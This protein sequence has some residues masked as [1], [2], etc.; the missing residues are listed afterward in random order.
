MVQPS[1][2][3]NPFPGLRPFE[4]DEEHLFFGREGQADELL[5]RLNRTRFLA[6]VGTS[7]SGKSSLVRAGLLPSLYSGLMPNA[8]SGWRVA[9]L[10]PGHAPMGNLAEALNE[11]K[12]FGVDAAADDAIIR[13]ALT[14]STLRRGAL[15]LVEVARQA[16]M[17]NHES[18][19]VVVDQFEE[20]FR[21]K[22]QAQG[23]DHRLAV[24]D[25]AAAFVKLLLGAVNQQEVPI[26]VVLTMRS[27][28]LG[29]CAQFRDLPETL[30]NSQYLVPRLTREQLKLAIEGP[31]AVGGATITPRL[32]NRLLNDTG[33]NPDQLPILQH[34]LMRTW[35]YWEDQHQPQTPI[36]IEHY[37]AIGGMAKAL[38]RHADQIYEGLPDER[39]RRI[40]EILFRCLTTRGVDNRDI[41]RPTQLA[42]IC[43][44][45][46]AS[47]AEVI[48]VIDQFRA[49]RRSFLMP[50]LQ[51]SLHDQ[52]II[53]ISHESLMRNWGRLKTWVTLEEQSAQIYK[54]LA[55]TAELHARGEAGYLRDPELTI[56]LTWLNEQQPNKTWAERYAPNFD[57]AV[58]F[59]AASAEARDIEVA[60]AETA[61][62]QKI[63]QL[64]TFLGVLLGLSVLSIAF[65][66]FALNQ[67][68]RAED[69]AKVAETQ[70]RIA[71][72]Q[73]KIADRQTKIAN[74]KAVEA[75][76]ER[77]RA[78][79]KT[80]EAEQEKE[81]ALRE[82]DAA[83]KAKNEEA[84][85][86][87]I[88]L[89]ALDRAEKGEKEA[90]DQSLRAAHQA[91][92]AQTERDNATAATR[93]ALQEKSYAELLSIE[94][95]I[96]SGLYF[97]A[98]LN[99]LKIIKEIQT[100]SD[101]SKPNQMLALSS[102]REA[103]YH[104]NSSL[105]NFRERNRLNN[106]SSS[107][108]FSPDGQSVVSGHSQAIDFWDFAQGKSQR[109]YG[110]TGVV[111]SIAYS[112][113]NERKIATASHDG[114]VQ[115]WNLETIDRNTPPILIKDGELNQGSD[116]LNEDNMPTWQDSGSGIIDTF[117]DSY[118]FKG[119]ADQSVVINLISDQFD[120]YLI[121][122]DAKNNVIAYNDDSSGTLNSSITISL[123]EDGEYTIIATALYSETTGQYSLSAFSLDDPELS[124]KLPE[125]YV[126][127]IVF[128]PN[129]N[130]LAI[131][132]G[133]T[134]RIVDVSNE[135]LSKAI[136]SQP[137]VTIGGHLAA[138]N[139]LEFSPD[140][141]SIVSAGEDNTI[142]VWDLAANYPTEPPLLQVQDNLTENDSTSPEG[143]HY[144]A[145]PITVKAG[146]KINIAASSDS[147]DFPIYVTIKDSDGAV[148]SSEYTA[149]SEVNILFN[150]LE[151][152]NY[153][154]VVE[155]YYRNSF[156]SYTLSAS[157]VD[158]GK[159]SIKAHNGGV[160]DITFSSDG[161][162]ISTG[163]DGS[164]L[165]WNLSSLR[166]NSKLVSELVGELDSSDVLLDRSEV[167]SEKGAYYEV[168][169]LVGKA[170]DRLSLEL[171]SNIFDT[172]LY[173]EDPSGKIIAEDDDGY[174]STN[175]SLSISL[176]ED[177]EY[178]III[179][180][181]F[182]KT[183]GNY[184]LSVFS[185]ENPDLV[186][187]KHTELVNSI[188]ID[189][190]SKLLASAS[191]DGTIKLWDIRNG[192]ELQT[193]MGH[194]G[195]VKDVVF[196]PDG[197][198]LASSGEDDTVKL[199]Q[200]SKARID[201]SLWRSLEEF[202][203]DL[204][205]P[206]GISPRNTWEVVQSDCPF[207]SHQNKLNAITLEMSDGL[208]FDFKGH[209]D[210]IRNHSF[211]IGCE[212]MA[213]GSADGVIK[214]WDV[215][216]RRELQTLSSLLND[217]QEM[218]LYFSPDN[219][220]LISVTGYLDDG[221]Y[222]SIVWDF[223]AE[224]LLAKSCD[225]L[226]FY[227]KN[228]DTPPEEKALCEGVPSVEPLPL[229]AAPSSSQ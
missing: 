15:G 217:V 59:L 34:A 124:W 82:K 194:F 125:N 126:N 202:N 88:A 227:M 109:F 178:K 9:I 158:E 168:H 211:S 176:P 136:T 43:A 142:N 91:L 86:R 127:K 84:R 47:E 99:S 183:E 204:L 16:R 117:F 207:E 19:L 8:S 216:N 10:R 58:S 27:D 157:L 225:W 100:Q 78:E 174:F 192:Q 87:D 13:T 97:Q 120:T 173:L 228:P 115:I 119:K 31:V 189:S 96:G 101:F 143:Y 206:F 122:V 25:E 146:Q 130:Q 162:L 55:K 36:D 89:Q 42:E 191:N 83:D 150:P 163:G 221:R 54:R 56:G 151:D 195:N 74:E 95:Q 7:G 79:L 210:K 1:T 154:I 38:S 62:R 94:S 29:D 48:A 35:D 188:S 131:A 26:Y 68:K 114:T 148:A 170:G 196:S 160:F 93:L 4:L 23:H 169:S 179:S 75:D 67:Q 165:K 187:G 138:I 200:L 181:F 180:S 70:T 106:S 219:S 18:L 41:R 11:P 108:I 155:P 37:E 21:F 133:N 118:R 175:S 123:P 205:I 222:E 220:A 213:T 224:S 107:L 12:V 214:L 51:A 80:L 39:S 64:R 167:Y 44:V 111:N 152:N 110:P 30:N 77:E 177:G 17:E 28:F 50:P 46:H 135:S 6:V 32:V 134:I 52:T 201:R 139:D 112:P 98:M 144:R 71:N 66:G 218:Y 3:S 159:S 63:T 22:A 164:I 33:D 49:P 184:F 113:A 166:K 193:L 215:Q 137:E 153:T 199:W 145:Y 198:S 92:I 103:V 121:L 171:S 223:D 156:G 147:S 129:G 208:S 76:G 90:R 226:S 190:E 53:D 209:F 182:D 85:Q 172:Y 141:K 229:S 203:S 105:P 132:G 57:Q 140:G 73:R 45:A 2:R 161:K 186:V 104:A 185:A 81:N 212:I 40:A 60:E 5:A 24:E 197:E 61:R 128:S 20:L 72:R 149:H 69:Q 116:I 102:L 14:E 65:A